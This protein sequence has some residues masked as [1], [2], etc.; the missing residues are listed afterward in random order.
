MNSH[1][2]AILVVMVLLVGCRDAQPR[3]GPEAAMTSEALP[4]RAPVPPSVGQGGGETPGVVA[5]EHGTPAI[6]VVVTSA[7]AAVTSASESDKSAA[8]PTPASVGHAGS[9]PALST[10]PTSAQA[11]DG[12]YSAE[13][14]VWAAIQAYFPISDWAAAMSVAG[15]ETGG[16]YNPGLIGAHGEQGIY[17]VRAIYHGVVPADITGQ[18]AQA[19]GIVARYGWEPW[20]CAG[21]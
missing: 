6:T 10:T 18:V 12:Q 9:D 13:A 19:S 15:C 1:M 21:W 16:T 4:A 20:T 7:M 3:H 17:Q 2:P 11:A 5:G 8:S 14:E